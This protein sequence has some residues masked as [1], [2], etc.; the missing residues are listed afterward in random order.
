VNTIP[1]GGTALAAAI[2]TALTAFREKGHY[3]ALVL[4]TDGEDNDNAAA[5][6]AAAQDAA[7][8]GLKIFT[9]GIGTA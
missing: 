1:Q 4:L 3:K 2:N 7:K 9:I 5:A 8:A 6:L